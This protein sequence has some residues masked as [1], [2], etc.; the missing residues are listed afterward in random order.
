M[1]TIRLGFFGLFVVLVIILLLSKHSRT[2]GFDELSENTEA[3]K[4]AYAYADQKVKE[5]IAQGTAGD[6]AKQREIW[7][8]A[9]QDKN[10]ELLPPIYN[11]YHPN[12]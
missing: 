1:R 11:K 4:A 2:E 7:V 10:D 8:N 3:N 5:A 6:D 12:P 9:Y